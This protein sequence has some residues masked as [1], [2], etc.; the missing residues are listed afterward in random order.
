MR[1]ERPT[2]RTATTTTTPTVKSGTTRTAAKPRASRSKSTPVAE[3][4]MSSAAP[5]TDEMVAVRAYEIFLSRNGAEGDPI[6]DWLQ[7]EKE[8]SRASAERLR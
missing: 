3:V 5:P 8:L 2:S 1:T 6:S 7:A 4:A